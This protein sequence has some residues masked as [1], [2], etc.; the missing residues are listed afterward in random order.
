MTE[1][2]IDPR[3]DAIEIALKAIAD[4]LSESKRREALYEL[5][6]T[7]SALASGAPDTAAAVLRLH[8]KLAGP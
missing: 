4:R 5:G 8:A 2:A 6:A 3:A 7:A 1:P